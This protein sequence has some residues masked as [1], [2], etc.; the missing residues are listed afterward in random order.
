MADLCDNCGNILNNW[1]SINISTRHHNIQSCCKSV[2]HSPVLSHLRTCLFHKLHYLYLCRF[3]CNTLRGAINK[4]GA[5][6]VLPL[7]RQICCHEVAGVHRYDVTAG[8][9]RGDRGRQNTWVL[10]CQAYVGRCPG[11]FRSL[12]YSRLQAT[13]VTLTGFV[14]SFALII[15][16]K[17]GFRTQ[18]LLNTRLVG[19]H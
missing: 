2:S 6:T 15:I 9:R 7:C 14:L 18:E 8:T 17:V 10:C 3:S 1:T 4:P 12:L 13:V 11:R 19:D 16:T 5:C